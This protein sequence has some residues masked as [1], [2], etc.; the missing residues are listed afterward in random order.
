MVLI[1]IVERAQEEIPKG[2]IFLF[3]DMESGEQF[4]VDTSIS[5]LKIENSLLPNHKNIIK[6]YSDEDFLKPLRLF[7]RRRKRVN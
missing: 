3:E 2:A 4:E 6:I 7:F 5:A 1:N